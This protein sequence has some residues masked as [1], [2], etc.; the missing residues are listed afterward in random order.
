MSTPPFRNAESRIHIMVLPHPWFF[1]IPFHVLLFLPLLVYEYPD[2]PR[3]DYSL[4]RIIAAIERFTRMEFCQR[5][6]SLAILPV[7]FPE[8]PCGSGP[9]IYRT[10]YSLPDALKTPARLLHLQRFLGPWHL[11][12]PPAGSLAGKIKTV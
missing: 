1:W 2:E 5:Y 7:F 4:K 3:K 6:Q 8:S 9:A 11:S 10:F 12:S